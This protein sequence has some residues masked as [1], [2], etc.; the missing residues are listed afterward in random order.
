MSEI[1]KYGPYD[2]QK[3]QNYL[4]HRYPFLFVDKILSVEVPMKDGK[5]QTI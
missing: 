2:N 4:P 5:K 3:V 1:K